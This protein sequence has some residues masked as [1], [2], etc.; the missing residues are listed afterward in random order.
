[1]VYEGGKSSCESVGDE[2][3][4]VSEES[5]DFLMMRSICWLSKLKGWRRKGDQA[6][7]SSAMTHSCRLNIPIMCI[8]LMA[9]LRTVCHF[10]EDGRLAELF[11]L[12]I[13]AM[14]AVLP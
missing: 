13:H 11:S 7:Y 5:E 1:M 12:N 6:Q 8:C 10:S 4:N 9:I 3:N 14:P 2:D